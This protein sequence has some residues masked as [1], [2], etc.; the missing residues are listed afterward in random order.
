MIWD[1]SKNNVTRVAERRQ[2]WLLLKTL[3]QKIFLDAKYCVTQYSCVCNVA[4]AISPDRLILQLST[5]RL[6]A[7]KKCR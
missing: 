6:F 4:H 5:P 2:H 3:P 1:V 7:L